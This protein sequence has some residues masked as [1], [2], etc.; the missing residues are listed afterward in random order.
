MRGTKSIIIIEEEREYHTC[1]I[2]CTTLKVETNQNIK[3]YD[4]LCIYTRNVDLTCI[5]ACMCLAAILHAH[6]LLSILNV[7][8]I[9]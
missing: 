1:S 8:I 9:L 7:S 3:S 5:G 6:D 4:H 2:L